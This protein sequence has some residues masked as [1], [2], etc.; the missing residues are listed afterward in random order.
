MFRQ[1]PQGTEFPHRHRAPDA[2]QR[3]AQAAWCAADPGPIAEQESVGPG[4]AAHRRSSAAPRPGQGAATS[5]RTALTQSAAG[6]RPASCKRKSR[7]R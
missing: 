5:P 7:P 2:A 3:A 6:G 4:S 1:Y